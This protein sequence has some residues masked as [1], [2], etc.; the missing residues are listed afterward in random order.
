MTYKDAINLFEVQYTDLC[1]QRNITPLK[2]SNKE[3]FTRLSIIQSELSNV[4][5]LYDK[6]TTLNL[7]AGTY[8]Y[9][10]ETLITDCLDVIGITYNNLNLEKISVEE[11]NLIV[12]SQSTPTAYTIYGIV[13]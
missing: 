6:T 5:R 4:Y 10:L 2:F 8:E 9:L 13:S 11:M 1:L 3:I 7:T 12:N